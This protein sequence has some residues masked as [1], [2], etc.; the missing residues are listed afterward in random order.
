MN[1]VPLGRRRDIDIH[2][3]D[4]D[5]FDITREE[6]VLSDLSGSEASCE[7]SDNESENSH[8]DGEET[9]KERPSFVTENSSPNKERI[10]PLI[11]E[12][13]RSVFEESSSLT[14]T[15]SS[16]ESLLKETN[17]L[18]IKSKNKKYSN[19]S[20]PV[21]KEVKRSDSSSD[22]LVKS[23][24]SNEGDKQA[25][26]S[27]SSKEPPKVLTGWQK[28]LLAR[29]E[30]RK[31]LAEDPAFVPHL[32]EF[33]GHDDRF[34]KE[35][36]KNDFDPRP[37]NLPFG[38][39]GRA[40]WGNSPPRGRWDHNGFEELMRI[41]EEEIRRKEFQRRAQQ[42][43]DFGWLPS[44][45]RR[46]PA[47][48]FLSPPKVNQN[49]SIKFSP[50]N[51]ESYKEHPYGFESKESS[52][53]KNS[54]EG[55]NLHH[56]INH[57]THEN[58][59]ENLQDEVEEN[60]AK[61]TSR[62]ND[63]KSKSNTSSF[64]G[65]GYIRNPLRS[66]ANETQERDTVKDESKK[67]EIQGSDIE[68]GIE[69][70]ETQKSCIVEDEL[71]QNETQDDSIDYSSLPNE[72]QETGIVK[73][74]LKQ[75]ELQG[76]ISKE[77]N[78]DH[79]KKDETLT[80][81]EGYINDGRLNIASEYWVELGLSINENEGVTEGSD[82][83]SE[84][85]IILDSPSSN[86]NEKQETD[87][88][89]NEKISIKFGNHSESDKSPL[90]KES[91]NSTLSE[92]EQEHSHQIT[93]SKRY[94]TR[95][96]AASATQNNQTLEVNKEA[97]D[98]KTSEI[99]LSAVYAPPFKPRSMTSLV[100]ENVIE[101]EKINDGNQ[102]SLQTPEPQIRY[103]TSNRAPPVFPLRNYPAE[104]N[105]PIETPPSTNSFAAES[106]GMVYY[107]DP[108]VYYVY[109]N[110]NAT[111]P[112]FVTQPPPT[113]VTQPPPTNAHERNGVYYFYP[114]YYP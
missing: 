111:K 54:K 67:N 90:G 97:K 58:K 82:E 71:K 33:W 88:S 74:E 81:S 104:N 44:D 87:I 16:E 91:S 8:T 83:E 72:T 106:N 35:E 107:Y 66:Q 110:E 62:H 17:E 6:L 75:S 50:S 51:R 112:T 25:N 105:L 31:K 56:N 65:R 69:Q 13:A 37:R 55:G 109:G 39:K 23:I 18:T 60:N 94:S 46:P 22:E 86:A 92:Q 30:Y 113:I 98:I 27:D 36:L 21:T 59:L 41:E 77:H 108:N 53:I 84:V 43:R 102:S 52:K 101:G 95:R 34:I 78:I 4:E 49:R 85:E 99:P 29:Q 38:P 1:K 45:R 14:D 64:R 19:N 76:D 42:R 79:D 70:N 5:E 114:Q 57:S 28:K 15:T 63:Q 40:V 47:R 96:V 20:G 73:Y 9:L 7:D 32:G 100:K 2:S 26:N 61:V 93:H 48:N 10:A 103:Y 80:T 3:E 68:V 12:D 24:S 11:T 89:A